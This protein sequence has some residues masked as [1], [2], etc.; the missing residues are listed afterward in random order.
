M[1]ISQHFNLRA[2]AKRGLTL[3]ELAIAMSTAM[4]IVLIGWATVE[5]GHRNALIASARAESNRTIF[6]VMQSI[7]ENI[8]QASAIQIPDPSYPDAN[9][10]QI[11]V[12]SDAGDV[13]RA[14]RL[15]AGALVI[16]YK[17]EEASAFDAFEGVTA[18]AFTALDSPTNSL[19][20]V[21]CTTTVDDQAV[22]MRT[23]TR[24]R[25]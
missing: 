11:T 13:R 19:I 15:E 16:D 8:M 22:D 3:V 2:K 5:M 20:E 1:R 24:K 6:A 14:Y 23:V 7:E 4:V 12:P 25:N 18:L 10:I 9:S 17:D 21:T